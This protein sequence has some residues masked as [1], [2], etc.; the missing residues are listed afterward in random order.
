MERERRM[1]VCSRTFITNQDWLASRARLFCAQLELI[2]LLSPAHQ[3]ISCFFPE[4]LLDLRPRPLSVSFRTISTTLNCVMTQW[5]SGLATE[6][7]FQ[8]SSNLPKGRWLHWLVRPV[9]NASLV[10]PVSFLAIIDWVAVE[11]ELFGNMNKW[12]FNI[13]SVRKRTFTV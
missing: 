4:L 5:N 9:L 7:S 6:C 8:D 12:A 2:R 11:S 13:E 3:M 1:P 10:K